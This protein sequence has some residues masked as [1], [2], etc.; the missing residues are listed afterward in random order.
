[1]NDVFANL[2]ALGKHRA[3][4][5]PPAHRPPTTR[6]MIGNAARAVATTIKNKAA[7]VDV[8]QYAANLA[9]CKTCEFW[10]QNGWAGTGKCTH[11]KCGCSKLKQ[12]L[13]GQQCP[14][15]PPKWVNLPKTP[16][17]QPD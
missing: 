16:Q 4:P 11:Q 6:Q 13:V 3:L 5:R 1:M 7:I 10:D 2:A 8:D 17:H 9:I 14:L 15:N 12:K